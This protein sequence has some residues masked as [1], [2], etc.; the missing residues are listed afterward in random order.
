MG[1]QFVSIDDQRLRD[2]SFWR[3]SGYS[4]HYF[5]ITPGPHTIRVAYY[6]F[7]SSEAKSSTYTESKS[8][9]P[10]NVT[11]EPGRIYVVALDEKAF[12]NSKFKASLVKLPLPYS[13]EIRRKVQNSRWTTGLTY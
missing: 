10:L 4:S 2:G 11:I 12:K 6:K 8:I 13:D 9:I 1:T 3:Y 5:E 7:K